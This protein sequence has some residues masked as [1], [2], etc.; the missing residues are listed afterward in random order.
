MKKGRLLTAVLGVFLLLAGVLTGCSSNSSAS[1][2]AGS[3]DNKEITMVFYPNESAKNFT[4]SRKALQEELHKATG[5]K[6]IFKQQLI[7]TWRL[8]LSLQVKHN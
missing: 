6:T 2:K 3:K 8:L 5:K 1:Q 7:T 4:A